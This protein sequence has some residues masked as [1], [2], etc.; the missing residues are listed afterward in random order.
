MTETARDMKSILKCTP[1]LRGFSFDR[2]HSPFTLA[3]VKVRMGALRIRH[4]E[5]C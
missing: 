2:F 5:P 3:R 4:L 1:M